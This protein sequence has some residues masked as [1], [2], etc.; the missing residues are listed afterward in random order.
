VLTTPKPIGSLAELVMPLSRGKIYLLF[1]LLNPDACDDFNNCVSIAQALDVN[2][3]Q[4]NNLLDKLV[5]SR[6]VT[7]EGEITAQN[8]TKAQQTLDVFNQA[9]FSGLLRAYLFV[10][11][12]LASYS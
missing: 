3:A 7:V 11:G 2:M 1:E 9:Q 12:K 5:T 6:Y 4:P 10:D 8:R